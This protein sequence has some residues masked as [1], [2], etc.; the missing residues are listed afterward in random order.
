MAVLLVVED[1]H[2]VRTAIARGLR[3]RGHEVRPVGTALAALREIACGDV[4]L[5][6]L[7]LRLPDLDG[8]Q[9]LKL[10]RGV[11]DVPVIVSTERADQAG[12]VALL[13]A[14]ADSYLVKPFAEEN[15]GARVAALLRR[16][17]PE[18]AAPDVPL[19]V[20][21]L[22]IDR[23]GREATLSGRRLELTRREFDLLA[24]LAGQL[25][26]VVSRAEL[27]REVWH[28][29]SGSCGRSIDVHL[30]W[31]RG[32]LGETAARPVFLRTVRGVGL[33]L[34][35]PRVEDAVRVHDPASGRADRGSA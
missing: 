5:V 9:A 6:I 33:M 12:A 10:I 2:G 16:S 32:K 11:S 22:R 1:D 14:G 29:P 3:D 17:R 7:D 31:L 18:P 13:E 34:V 4:D 21:P 20:G 25:G 15:L 23:A 8:A 35:E 30:S 19:V 24:Y 28:Q 27:S 26:R